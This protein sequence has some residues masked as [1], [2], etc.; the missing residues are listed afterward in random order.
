MQDYQHSSFQERATV[1]RLALSQ[2]GAHYVNGGTG[3]RPD[4]PTELV[5]LYPTR[6]QMMPNRFDRRRSIL[7]CARSRMRVDRF[8]AGRSELYRLC[9]ASVHMKVRV[10]PVPRNQAEC[11]AIARPNE[12]LWPRPADLIG[13]EMVFGEACENI[14]HFDCVMFVN[15]C[16]SSAVGRA[17]DFDIYETHSH[18]WY[19]QSVAVWPDPDPRVRAMGE[20]A[21]AIW[22]GDLVFARGGGHVG[23]ATGAIFSPPDH[24]VHAKDTRWGVR[25]EPLTLPSPETAIQ[26]GTFVRRYQRYVDGA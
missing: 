15:W 19:A 11:D 8:C 16:F 23:M 18:C 22:A 1:I 9:D 24:L 7:H 21:A 17:L 5:W 25:L 13:G 2:V 20:G 4:V 14:R 6:V 12:F 3:G 10:N 26:H